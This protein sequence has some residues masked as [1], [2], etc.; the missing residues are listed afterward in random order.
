MKILLDAAIKFGLC[1]TPDLK[2][3]FDATIE[4]EYLVIPWENFTILK[5]HL[6][7]NITFDFQTD[8]EQIWQ[9]IRSYELAIEDRLETKSVDYHGCRANE[10]SPKIDAFEYSHATGGS[11]VV[12]F[13]KEE[14]LIPV[15]DESKPKKGIRVVRKYWNCDDM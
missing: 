2:E 7:N 13:V 5:E 11:A 14:N 9:A 10:R 12:E 4:G 6:K 1:Y 15:K 3:K 8:P